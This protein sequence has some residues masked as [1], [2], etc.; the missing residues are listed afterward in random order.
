MLVLPILAASH[1]RAGHQAIGP[2]G[3][4][5]NARAQAVLDQ[6]KADWFA[7]RT[8]TAEQGLIAATKIPATAAEAHYWL[9]R[10]YDFKG[11][12]AEGA[13]PGFHEEV[14]YRPRAEAEFKAAG[15]P[16]P[17]WILE[18]DGFANSLK[19]ADAAIAKLQA[20]AASSPAAIRS[21][22]EYRIKL[23]PDPMSY[24]S[25]ANILLARQ[26]DLP[27]VLQ[28]AAEGKIAGERFIREN[29]SS[30]KLDGKVLAS[31]DRNA[32]TFA[33]IAGWAL[34]L[35]GDLDGAEARLAEAARLFRN[36]DIN[37]QLH[38]AELSARKGDEDT[39]QEHYLNVIEL[40]SVETAQ[41]RGKAVNALFTLRAKTG[42]S[43]DESR[44]WLT[45][46]LERKREERREALLGDMQ[47]R[48]VPALVLKDL[49]GKSVDLRAERGN[50]VLLNFFSAW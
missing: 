50:V 10:I 44:R 25:G 11:N 14:S 23:R 27:F 17:E 35:Q 3:R 12:K 45:G 32:A 42:E 34:F 49:Q 19:Q 5:A 47:G 7:M 8:K 13:F 43:F 33:D 21:A 15:T 36:N 28:L 22:I 2:S 31:L 24:S 48:R 39:A 37:N 16:R 9:G 40:A 1:V 4:Q 30:Y 20:D 38:L 18:A 29:E 6:G 41:Q 26:A 46:T